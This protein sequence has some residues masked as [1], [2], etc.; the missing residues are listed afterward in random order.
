MTLHGVRRAHSP[1]GSG[2]ISVAGHGRIHELGP[3]VD[4]AL[5]V[6]QIPET[7]L[8]QKILRRGLAAYAMVAVEHDRRVPIQVQEVVVTLLV[9]EP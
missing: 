6:V 5:Q 3:G 7:V 9:E 4:S 8:A 1:V 2:R